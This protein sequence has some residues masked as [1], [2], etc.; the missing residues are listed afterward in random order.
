MYSNY[1]TPQ[2]LEAFYRG[3]ERIR[4]LIE[5]LSEKEIKFNLIENKWTIAEII[6]HLADAEI[7]GACRLRMMYCGHSEKL[8]VYDPTQWA[9]NMKYKDFNMDE[10]NEA[11]NLF[12][13]LRI[14]SYNLFKRF[15][16][17]DWLKQGNHPERGL[18]TIREWLELYSD[19]SERHIE[20]IL[21]RRKL[22]NK[23]LKMDLILK[24]RLY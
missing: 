17:S 2:L 22:L 13:Y 24:D 20:Q 21:H 10:I 19:H 15:K 5:G 18:M 6:V 4:T 7:I 9:K 16:P 11:I 3:P 12:H 23:E 14:A 8:P 1:S